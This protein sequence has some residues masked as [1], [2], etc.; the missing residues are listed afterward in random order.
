[1]SVFIL[2]TPLIAGTI[3]LFVRGRYAALTVF[4]VYLSIE[5][6]IK[7]LGNYHPAVHI[8]VDIVLWMLVAG[9]I[10]L[11][12]QWRALAGA[13]EFRLLIGLWLCYWLPQL[14]SCLDAVNPEESWRTTLAALRFP[15]VG[16]YVIANLANDAARRL[17]WQLAAGLVIFWSLDAS[18]QMLV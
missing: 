17:L 2:A 18:L 3:A 8:G 13:R 5:G 11:A 15:L 6:L 12:R 9:I 10:V 16:A 1:M 14:F 7:L 4:F